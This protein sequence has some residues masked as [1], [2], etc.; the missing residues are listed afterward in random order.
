MTLTSC[1]A[2]ALLIIIIKKNP[3]V[4]VVSYR[5]TSMR[6]VVAA[7]LAL[8]SSSA[9]FVPHGQACQGPDELAL[10]FCNAELPMAARVADL[11]L[12]LTVPE[13]IGLA[14]MNMTHCWGYEHHITANDMSSTHS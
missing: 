14:G 12:R 10:P 9:A 6:L 5:Y 13:K 11:L 4:F 7:M 1:A 3:I 8:L 2:A